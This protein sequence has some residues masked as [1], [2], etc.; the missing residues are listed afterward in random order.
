MHQAYV[1][2]AFLHG[3]IDASVNMEWLKGFEGQKKEK[4]LKP[5][6]SLYDIK[7]VPRISYSALK[8]E[9]EESVFEASAVS[10]CLFVHRGKKAYVVSYVDDALILGETDDNVEVAKVFSSNIIT[11]TDMGRAEFFI[12]SVIRQAD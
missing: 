11:I 2:T 1:K 3:H 9:L 6:R 7:Q 4:A 5:K 8:K 10:P 12:G